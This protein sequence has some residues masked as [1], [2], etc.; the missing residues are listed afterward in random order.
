MFFMMGTLSVFSVA[1][2]AKGC[3]SSVLVADL[4]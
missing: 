3:H 2:R 1:R 4:P